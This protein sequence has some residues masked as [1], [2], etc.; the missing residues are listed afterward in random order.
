MSPG[1][2]R[3]LGGAGLER[4]L[5]SAGR[6]LALMP[7][8][9]FDVIILLL[10]AMV[11]IYLFIYRAPY[12]AVGFVVVLFAVLF[13]MRQPVNLSYAL[14]A[15][16]PVYWMNLLGQSLRVVT[17]L[18]LIG[19]TY[20]LGR[21]VLRRQRGLYNTVYL[22]FLLYLITCL[23]SLFNSASIAEES[24]PGI[25]YFLL[26][27][28]L[29]FVLTA[30]LKTERDLRILFWILLLWGLVESVLGLLQ[31]LVSPRFYLA[32]TYLSIIDAYSVG[33]VRRASGTF[34][35][36]PRY[37]MYL[38][39]PLA[40]VVAGL[41]SGRILS[42]RTWLLFLVPLVGGVFVSLT[43]IAVGLSFA[44][45]VLFNFFERRRKALIASLAGLLLAAVVVATVLVV[46]PADVKGAFMQRFT[47]KDDEIYTDRLYFLWNA[48]GAF[49]EHP[50][51]GIGVG[52]YEGR[53]WEFMQKYPLPWRQYRWDVAAQWSMPETVPVHNEYGRML[54]EQGLFS[55]PVFLFLLWAAFRNLWFVIHETQRP[56]VRLW[57]V[58]VAM[59]LSAM[60]VYWYFHEYFMEEPYTSIMPFALS[61]ILY[62][63]VRREVAE[64]ASGETS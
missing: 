32:Q 40:L 54:A 46:L 5:R 1:G 43:R 50:F 13:L 6:S 28:M 60:V 7:R 39:G 57:G 59:Y 33:G 3:D 27:L 21:A 48:L 12:Y 42:R 8:Q 17:V 26:A 9:I 35:I 55:L 44:Y 23:F 22:G 2:W 34:Q 18:T 49:S 52:T 11:M 45:L 14:F 58:A 4:G 24:W 31:T 19:F 64:R 38:M 37:A 41:F 56:L 61:V 36:G 29:M 62:N 16:I 51:L 15:L 25:K 10:G 47:E 63:F 30:S 20:H 53:S